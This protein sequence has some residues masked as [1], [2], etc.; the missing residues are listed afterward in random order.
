LALLALAGGVVLATAACGPAAAQRRAAASDDNAVS[1]IGGA[2]TPDPTSD[3]TAPAQLTRT[4]PVDAT[5]TPGHQNPRPS[6]SAKTSTS[7]T[8][9]PVIVYFRIQQKPKCKG[10]SGQGPIVPLIIEW[11]VTGADAVTMSTD[12]AT[13]DYP[14]SGSETYVFGCAGAAGSTDSHTY[15]LKATHA[16]AHAS[17]SLTASAVVN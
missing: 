2:P 12:G 1:G 9:A 6:G 11:Q 5:G 4:A 16:G 8:P 10:S 13:K 17:K 7:A 15:T 14:A 3:P